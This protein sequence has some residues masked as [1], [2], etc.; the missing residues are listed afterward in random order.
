MSIHLDDKVQSHNVLSRPSLLE[1]LQILTSLTCVIFCDNKI[2][3]ERNV[4]HFV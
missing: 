1:N 2:T 3:M 4:L